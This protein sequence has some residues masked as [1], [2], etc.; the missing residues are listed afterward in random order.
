MATT[1]FNLRALGTAKRG[2]TLLEVVLALMLTILLL[3]GVFQ[4]YQMTL[5]AREAGTAA[6]RESKLARSILAS[7]AEEIRHATS[8]VPGDGIGFRGEQ[9]K[10]TIVKVGLTEHYA[11]DE[12]DS[13]KDKL[14]PAQLDLRRITYELLWDED[15]K[16]DQG[17][18]LCHGMWRTE[19]RTFD[20]NPSFVVAQNETPGA[21]SSANPQLVGPQPEGE[22]YAPEVKFLEFAYFD[23]AQWRDRWQGGQGGGTAGGTGSTATGGTSAASGGLG[24]MDSGAAL[25]QAVRITIG[26]VRV[27]PD[28]QM[29]DLTKWNDLEAHP[30][31]KEYHPDRFTVVVPLLEADRTLMSSRKYGVADSMARQEGGATK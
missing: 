16:D 4:F 13:L 6:T 5:Q 11:F 10:I 31:Q 17:V 30:E 3:A 18:R 8:I 9:N 27:D 26:K 22:L 7:I 12:Y 29:F 23:G 1:G 15:K 14:P 25:P 2:F 19:Q 24:P 21:E 20:P 28:N